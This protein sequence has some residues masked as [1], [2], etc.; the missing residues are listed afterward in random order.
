MYIG[1]PYPPVE[2][3]LGNHEIRP[4][5]QSL[6]PPLT[7]LQQP[8]HYTPPYSPTLF[9]DFIYLKELTKNIVSWL[10]TVE[11]DLPTWH[12]ADFQHH[13][14]SLHLPEQP[15]PPQSHCPSHTNSLLS[16]QF[17]PPSLPNNFSALQELI[18]TIISWLQTV[19]AE[20]AAWQ[21]SRSP[22]STTHHIRDQ[23]PVTSNAAKQTTLHQVTPNCADRTSLQNLPPSSP[24]GIPPTRSALSTRHTTDTQLTDPHTDPA[25]PQ[26]VPTPPLTPSVDHGT[27]SSTLQR[28]HF[29]SDQLSHNFAIY[30]EPTSLL[31]S[32]NNTDHT[33]YDHSL[34]PHWTSPA[35]HHS[36]QHTPHSNHAPRTSPAR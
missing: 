25:S 14:S 23:L 19:D 30:Q 11:A 12:S 29:E 34:G 1:I 18:Q 10:Q 8:L 33:E 36:T 4:H 9:P 24:S 16:P 7:S 3:H 28:S 35:T 22:C 26:Q 13:T 5:L 21:N 32:S 15:R 17:S 2:N 31:T 6:P 27:T 20:F